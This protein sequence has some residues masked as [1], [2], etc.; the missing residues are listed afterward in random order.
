MSLRN[1]TQCNISRYFQSRMFTSIV[2]LLVMRDHVTFRNYVLPRDAILLRYKA[3]PHCPS[4]RL[5]RNDPGGLLRSPAVGGIK[6]H[7]DS[8]RLSVSPPVCPSQRRAA[9]LGYRHAG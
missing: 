3:M 8:A 2:N 6:R 9:A 5:L 1:K 4:V 7:R